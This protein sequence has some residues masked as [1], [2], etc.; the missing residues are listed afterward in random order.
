[1][2]SPA[3][4]CFVRVPELPEVET[5]RRSLIPHL[6]GRR[7]ASVWARAIKLREGI[8]PSEWQRLVGMELLTIERT[9]KFLIARFERASALFHLGMSG[10]MLLARPDNELAPHTHLRL[11][12]DGDFELRFADARRFGAAIVRSAATLARHRSL[13]A[14]GVD[15][16]TGDVEGALLAAARSRS[17]IRSVLLDQRVLAGLG[18]IYANEALYRAGIRPLR[19]M[20]TVGRVRLPALAAAIRKV[21]I[22]ALEAGGTTLR[23]GGFVDAAG[24]NG[25][26]AV[27]LA[28]YGRDGQPCEECGATIVRQ[29]ATG[30]SAYF[31]PRCQR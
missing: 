28:V 14:L 17:P 13:Q 3:C 2:F 31:C 21:L 20:R 4:Y 7:V 11:G 23:D 10:R 12:F 22:Q 24:K 26:F 25:A 16:L 29:M 30:R 8:V 27:Q 15:P 5:V 19:Q 6:V 18:N 1:M 9:G